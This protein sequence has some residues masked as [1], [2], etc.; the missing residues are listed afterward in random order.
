MRSRSARLTWPLV[1]V[2]FMAGA[3]PRAAHADPTVPP[4]TRR[5]FLLGGLPVPPELWVALAKLGPSRV[6][7]LPWAS[8]DPEGSVAA[9][10]KAASAALP[11]SLWEVAAMPPFDAVGKRKLLDQLAHADAILALGGDQNK[12][13]DVAYGDPEIRAAITS[14]YEAG[15]PMLANDGAAIAMGSL[16]VTGDDDPTV[17]DGDTVGVRPGLGLLPRAIVDTQFIKRQRSYRM[18][19]LLIKNPEKIVLGIDAGTAFVLTDQCS[20]VVLAPADRPQSIAIVMRT[21]ETARPGQPGHVDLYF[22]HPGETFTCE[23]LGGR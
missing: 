1:M 12:F 20:G 17:V 3:F 14:R 23:G 2:G 22:F 6:I 21:A 19:G 9:I 7:V 8:G 4:P 5:M 13:L 18:L 15:I 11:A 10:K 16:A